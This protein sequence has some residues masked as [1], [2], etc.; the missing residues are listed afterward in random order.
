MERSFA[1]QESRWKLFYAQRKIFKDIGKTFDRQGSFDIFLLITIFK[2]DD[3]SYSFD[4]DLY[5]EYKEE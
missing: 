4:S 3:V 5:D 1:K 2:W